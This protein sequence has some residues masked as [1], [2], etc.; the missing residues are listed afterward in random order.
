MWWE[1]RSLVA[2]H[3]LA[4]LSSPLNGPFHKA[5]ARARPAL[6]KERL[7]EPLTDGI[8][9]ALFLWA[10]VA[11]IKKGAWRKPEPS[12]HVYVRQGDDKPVTDC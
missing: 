6:G 11:V 7:M 8:L 9:I 1:W 4:L 5:A 12:C 3:P 10:T 2:G